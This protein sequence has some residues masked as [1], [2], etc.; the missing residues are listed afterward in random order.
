MQPLMNLWNAGFFA[1][2]LLDGLLALVAILGALKGTPVRA[3]K[4]FAGGE[5]PEV[6][7]PAFH[8]T[9]EMLIHAQLA[10]AHDVE[11]FI[12]GDQTYPRL[13]GDLRGAR[14]SITVQLYTRS[15]SPLAFASTNT[16]TR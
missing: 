4:A 2:G 3:V 10:Y 1:V 12:N 9:M 14:E 13:W 11:I 15:F 16:R 5:R 8:D 6:H 7:E